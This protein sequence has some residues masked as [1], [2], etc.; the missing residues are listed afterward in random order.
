[1][2]FCKNEYV[3]DICSVGVATNDMTSQLNEHTEVGREFILN[4]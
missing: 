2:Y 3:Y 4:I 1:M